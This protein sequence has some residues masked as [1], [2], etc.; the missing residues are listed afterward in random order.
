M[1]EKYYDKLSEIPKAIMTLLEAEAKSEFPKVPFCE[2]EFDVYSVKDHENGKKEH[3]V[4][5]WRMD[6]PTDCDIGIY[7][8]IYQIDDTLYPTEIN[9]SED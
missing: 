7:A 5:L 9:V 3:D 1:T 8:N 6:H 4:S 2:Y